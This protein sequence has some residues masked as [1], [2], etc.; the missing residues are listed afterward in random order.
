VHGL[1]LELFEIGQLVRRSHLGLSMTGALAAR[2]RP[3]AVGDLPI[4]PGVPA[5]PDR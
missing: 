5:E 3:G 1:G 4:L 2:F